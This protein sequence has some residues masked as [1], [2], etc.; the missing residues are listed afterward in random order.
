MTKRVTEEIK[1]EGIRL[2]WPNFAGEKRQFNENGER[3][4]GIEL[5]EESADYYA[6]LGWPVKER[7]KADEEGAMHKLYHLPVKVNMEGKRPPSLFL[8]SRTFD[9]QPRRT[10]LDEDTV[11]ILDSLRFSDV[12]VI[13]S[14]YNWKYNGREGVA[15]YLKTGFFVLLQDDLERKYAHIPIDNGSGMPLEIENIVD[16]DAQ[17]EDDGAEPEQFSISGGQ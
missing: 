8:I 7:E 17:W 16:V 14:P 12:D 2:L 5:D 1:L 3:N 4:F 10:K 9:D 11:E 13:L 6:G 15:A